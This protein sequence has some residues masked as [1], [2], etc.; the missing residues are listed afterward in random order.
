MTSPFSRSDDQASKLMAEY[1]ILRV[2]TVRYHYKNWRYS[3][4][5]DALRQARREELFAAN[6]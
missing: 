4:L 5:D 3:N 1:G 2:E 6:S